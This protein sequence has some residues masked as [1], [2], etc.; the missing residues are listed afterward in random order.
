MG[1][2]WITRL[3]L[4]VLEDYTVKSIKAVRTSQ[5][6]IAIRSLRQ[7]YNYGRCAVFW[8]PC[9]M[10]ELRNRPIAVQ[11]GTTRAACKHEKKTDL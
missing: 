4:V 7:R 1:R 10:R 9:C 5:P 6:K 8:T 11:C 3:R 2:E